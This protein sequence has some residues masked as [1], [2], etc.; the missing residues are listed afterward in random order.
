VRFSISLP[1]FGELADPRLHAAM[2]RDAE[3][4][5]WDGYFVWDHLLVWNGNVVADPWTILAAVALATERIRL[6]PMLTP[7]PRRRPWQVVRQIVTLDHLS[8]GRAI[9]GAGLGYPPH[10]EFEVFGEPSDATTRAAI[11]DEGLEVVA[12][13]MTGEPFTFDGDHFH[14]DG[15]GFAPRPVQRPRVP[16]WIGGAWPRRAPFRRA[17]RFDGVVPIRLDDGGEE[18]LPTVD[19]MRAILAYTGEHRTGDGPFDA[20]FTGFMP[21][22]DAQA[23]E[24]AA[25]LSSFGVTWW[26]TSI[27]PDEDLASFRDLIRRGPPG[28]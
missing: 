3:E 20:V 21:D 16:I 19:D 7:L 10:E 23:A 9:F 25:E 12:G 26:Q 6:G 13:L 2:A 22:D 17:A 4:A 5:G 14:L 24:T 28:R 18:I 11:L 15:V 27:G 8:D 1:N